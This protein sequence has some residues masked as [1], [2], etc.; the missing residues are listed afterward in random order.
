[1]WII[2]CAVI[3]AALCAPIAAVAQTRTLTLAWDPSP[4]ANIDHY[5]VYIGS[6]SGLHDLGVQSVPTSPT[7]YS[8]SV[9]PGTLLFFTVSAVNVL[10]LES[11]LSDEFKVAVPTLVQ[12]ADQT[13][14][15]G[16]AIS[17][18][19][20]SASDPGGGLLQFTATG[21]PAGLAINGATGVISGT[22]MT[23]GT[24]T[25]TVSVNNGQL[26]TLQSFTW[27]ITAGPVVSTL[28][29]VAVDPSSGSGATGTFA[30][31]YS[32]SLGA[33]DL[34]TVYLKFST[35]PAEL[36]NTCTVSYSPS[37]GLFALRDDSGA[38]WQSAVLG[39]GTLQNSQC[40]VNLAVSSASTSGQILR[41]TL[42][43][44]F[45]SAF[46]GAKTVYSYA[47]TSA[48]VETG[49]KTVG[50]WSIPAA[51][52]TPA[53]S[54]ISVTPNDGFGASQ[55]FTAQFMASAGASS[56][57]SAYIRFST[58]SSGA[59]NTCMV[60]YNAASGRLS[61][62]DDSGEWQPGMAP[63]SPGV[64]QNTQCGLSV[65]GSSIAAVG[66]QLTLKVAM[67]FSPGYGGAK[68]IYLYASNANGVAVGW[69][70]HGSWNVPDADGSIGAGTVTPNSGMGAA[71]VFSAQFV[72][73]PN[74]DYVALAYLKFAVSP[75]GPVKTCM[76]QYDRVGKL[77]SL[78]DDAGQW[79]PGVPFSSGVSLEN[80]QCVVSTTGSSASVSGSVLTM[81]VAVTFK[82][83]YAGP[84][85]TYLYAMSE[86]GDLTGWQ[87]RGSWTV[88]SSGPTA[89]VSVGDVTPDAG[90]GSTQE[91]SAQFI[92]AFGAADLST[93]YIKIGGSPRG[94]VNTCMIRYEQTTGQVSLRDDA[95]QWMPGMTV[96][97]A[98]Q[99]QNAQCSVAIDAG[100]VTM[101]GTTLTL[102][103]TV[104]FQPTYQ[105]SK[106]VYLF[107][108]TAAGYVTDWQQ[109]GTWIVP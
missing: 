82:P 20:L 25:V 89:L 108:S 23:V 91:F 55:T 73:A 19:V 65:A 12:P 3:Y 14:T 49:W 50:S 11:P 90:S 30:A 87:Q 9:T 44:T 27:T 76:V 88:P 8:F 71:Q 57:A 10:G 13:A 21:L 51:S 107:A 64:Q 46:A 81:N 67:A 42:S 28:P 74:G 98:A 32:D 83:S 92:D 4:Q 26:T 24:S 63:G 39:W 79:Q 75:N 48:G 72:D 18:L 43:V 85:N 33:L 41:V 100:S 80:G 1:V 106:N 34:S 15:T 38:V 31:L 62:R 36:A 97:A 66:Q 47:T 61:L 53:L 17:P 103:I 16:G 2:V 52:A 101:S 70:Q 84:K 22:P 59:A 99:Q 102:T 77:L 109:R 29:S 56:I 40:S 6:H 78:R 104:G 7:T 37:T 54:T 94:A 68:G 96:N 95:G 45:N 86:L 35:T 69:R 60:R 93:M 5:V 105:G 58:A